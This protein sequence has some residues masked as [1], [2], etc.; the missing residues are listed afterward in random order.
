MIV[1]YNLSKTEQFKT[2][3]ILEAEKEGKINPLNFIEG[4]L[5]KTKGRIRFV[6]DS[7]AVEL[8]PN[9]AAT[10]NRLKKKQETKTIS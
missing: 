2:K 1:K 9:V 4:V 8:P 6:S 5:D 10:A 3:L 7:V